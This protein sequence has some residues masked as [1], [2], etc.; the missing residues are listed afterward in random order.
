MVR[1]S[2][3]LRAGRTTLPSRKLLQ[4][5][6]HQEAMVSMRSTITVAAVDVEDIK[7]RVE[8]GS[9]A[10]AVVDLVATSVE[11]E[12]V[13]VVTSVAVEVDS[14]VLLA[15][16]HPRRLVK[17][18]SPAMGQRT[19]TTTILKAASCH[20]HMSKTPLTTKS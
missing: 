11:G 10:V 6:L 9:G 12:A 14:V 2:L 13:A 5:L 17:S 19:R 4:A 20:Q 1:L 3:A 8:E 16:N 18:P 7:V 15:A